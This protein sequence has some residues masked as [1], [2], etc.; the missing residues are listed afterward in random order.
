MKLQETWLEMQLEQLKPSTRVFI[1][2]LIFFTVLFLGWSLWLSDILINYQDTLDK[3]DKLKRE[4]M[5]LGQIDYSRK[6]LSL[7]REILKTKK[8]LNERENRLKMIKSSASS[9]S[10]FWF[11][12]GKRSILLE[13]ILRKTL[14]LDLIVDKIEEINDDN[15]ESQ[16]SKMRFLSTTRFEVLGNGDFPAVVELASFIESTPYQLLKIEY[17]EVSS[18]IESGELKFSLIFD[19]YGEKK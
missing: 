19:L 9:N 11:D 16:E 7:E 8:L 13:E 14:E 4:L 1:A 15:N 17:L 6:R 2:F 10:F 5:R 3:K 18:D 12:D